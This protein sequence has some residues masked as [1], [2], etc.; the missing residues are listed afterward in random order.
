MAK[1]GTH[2]WLRRG[3]CTER[4]LAALGPQA[5]ERGLKAGSSEVTGAISAGCPLC[6]EEL[7]LFASLVQSG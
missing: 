4:K 7:D 3:C 5:V 1:I 6:I 2:A